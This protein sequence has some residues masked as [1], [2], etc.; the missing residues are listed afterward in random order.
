MIRLV[1]ATAVGVAGGRLAWLATRSLFAAPSLRRTNWRGREVATAAG[2]LLPLVLLL[3]EAGRVVAAAAGTGRP[4]TTAARLLVL[5]AA[6]GFA[7]LGAV[8]DLVGT[9]DDQGFRGHLRA[10]RQGRATT[11]LLK[12]VGGTALAL[13]VVGPTAGRS[14]GRLLADAALVAL[15]ANLANLLDRAPGRVVKA[16]ALALVVLAFAT[17]RREALDGVAVLTGAAF[18]LVPDDLGERLMLGDAGANALGGV[19]GLGVALTTS[20][21]ARTATLVTVAA[22]NLVGEVVSFSRVIDAVPPLRALDRAGRR[23]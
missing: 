1:V 12:L 22:L 16:G 13:A 3:V 19:L 10:L 8:D 15:A 18:G 21:G 11:G 14:L 17:R 9:A 6:L 4:G 7:L 20:P 23:R 5:T 2:I